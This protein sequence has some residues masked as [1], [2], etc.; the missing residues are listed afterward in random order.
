MEEEPEKKDKKKYESSSDEEKRKKATKKKKKHHSSDSD[1]DKKKK[2]PTKTTPVQVTNYPITEPLQINNPQMARG[3][4]WPLLDQSGY[5][6][7]G[8]CTGGGGGGDGGGMTR[9]NA[10]ARPFSSGYETRLVLNGGAAS[11]GCSSAAYHSH[12]L[13]TSTPSLSTT[14]TTSAQPGGCSQST[15]FVLNKLS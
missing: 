6:P 3:W 8:C 1:E 14:G 15:Q 11:C 13:S 9:L 10:P 2:T 5:A 7:P 4:M 12:G